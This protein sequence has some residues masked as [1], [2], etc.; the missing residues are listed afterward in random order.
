MKLNFGEVLT[1]AWQITWK[2]KVLWIFGILAGCGASNNNFNYNGGSNGGGGSG[3]NSGQLPDAL[4][5]FENMRPE[6]AFS[7]FMGQY[8]AIIVGVI[9]LLCVLSFLF[10]FLGVMGKTG[11]IKGANKADLGASSLGFGELWTESTPYFWRMFGLNLLIG[12]PIF[13]LVVILLA[14]LGF[15]GYS[16]YRGGLSGGGLSVLLI[17]MLGVFAVVMCIVGL[18]GLAIGML[19]KQAENAIILEDLGVLEGLSRGWKVFRSNLLPVILI[20][21]ILGVI[22][23]VAGLLMALPMI[24]IVLPAVIGIAAT[25]NA[26]NNAIMVPVIIACACALIY[27]PVLLTLS[28]ILQTY[29]QSVWTLTYRRLTETPAPVV[30]EA[31]ATDAVS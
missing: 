18:I 7:Q 30:A 3:G 5:Q 26:G 20:A 13:L 11:L 15:G 28:G 4:R 22:G 1:K 12:L 10:Y 27:M 25:A 9:L 2:F 16:A 19:V 23:W 8:M 6:Q 17:G 31:V 24:A 29:S 21:L 14:V